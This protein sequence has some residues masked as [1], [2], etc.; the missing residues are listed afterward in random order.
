MHF[1]LHEKSYLWYYSVRYSLD[2][3]TGHNIEEYTISLTAQDGTTRILAP[4]VA[5]NKGGGYYY[6]DIP[7]TRA[8]NLDKFET[9]TIKSI[10]DSTK[11]I[12][13]CCPLSDSEI[14][15][16]NYSQNDKLVNVLK[17]LYWYW[18]QANEY[19]N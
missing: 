6:V 17:A 16:E 4:S 19:K 13:M 10:S 12:E 2:I 14:V 15:V 18:K 11:K 8:Y 7:N 9:I 5:S 3:E 1:L